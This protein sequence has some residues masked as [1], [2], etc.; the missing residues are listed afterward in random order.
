MPRIYK[1][2]KKDIKTLNFTN[3]A[4]I[5]DQI[6][7]TVNNKFHSQTMYISERNDRASE[8]GS[9]K[10]YSVRFHYNANRVETTQITSK[11]FAIILREF[12][13]FIFEKPLREPRLN[14]AEIELFLQAYPLTSSSPLVKECLGFARK[15]GKSFRKQAVLNISAQAIC[16]LQ[17]KLQ[18]ASPD[19]NLKNSKR[20]K[21]NSIQS[22]TESEEINLETA[23]ELSTETPVPSSTTTPSINYEDE[24][25]CSPNFILDPNAHPTNLE[26]INDE[27]N[28]FPLD[29]YR[30]LVEFD[31]MMASPNPPILTMYRSTRERNTNEP[32][33]S[34]ASCVK[35]KCI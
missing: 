31:T 8:A 35:L 13:A 4:N 34:P 23:Y 1:T 19:E 17:E 22:V 16:D 29:V 5:L 9:Y 28:E 6:Q 32:E 30:F 24:N 7:E 18:R 21:I 2:T 11:A 26:C 14:C 20:R 25:A 27:E 3:P 10:R 15:A 33:L 12:L